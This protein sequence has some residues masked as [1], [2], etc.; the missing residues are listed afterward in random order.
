MDPV[1]IAAVASSAAISGEASAVAASTIEVTAMSPAVVEGAETAAEASEALIGKEGLLGQLDVIRHNS[2]ESVT[3]RNEA[4]IKTR[5]QELIGG[6]HSETGVPF[7]KDTIRLQDGTEREGVFP[8][9][10]ASFETTLPDELL[11]ATDYQQAQY[12]NE[13]LR[14]VVER[15]P[16]L[17][18]RFSE[19]QLQQVSE[20]NTPDG[21]TW[22]HHQESGRMQLVDS[23]THLKTGHT[24]GKEIWGGG[25]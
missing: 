2:L 1:T 22:H 18:E 24:G 10:D 21:F 23:I 17:K 5:N 4:L 7:V 20:A 12:C 9:F 6:A 14:D 3:A 15:D 19:T 8:E 11:K 16:S 25:R 13:Q